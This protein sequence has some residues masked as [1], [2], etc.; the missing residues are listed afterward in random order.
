MVGMELLTSHVPR[1]RGT[2]LLAHGYAEHS[3]RYG[4]LVASLN[5]AGFETVAYDLS[6][7]GRSPGPRARVDVGALIV[8]HLNVRERV[9]AEAR[10]PLSLFG[11]SMG[12][13]ITAASVLLRPYGVRAVALS[14]PALRPSGGISP[15]LARALLPLARLAPGLPTLRLDAGLLSR[16]PATVAAYRAAPLVYHGRV[17]LLTGLTMVIQGDQVIRNAPMLARP[18][19]VLHG[20]RDRFA[21][22][23]GSREFVA[24][25]KGHAQLRTVP[26]GYHEILNDPG[27]ADL[28]RDVAAWLAAQ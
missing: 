14:A 23:E 16:D 18:T 15:R 11:H 2:V 21:R 6:G 8:E 19:L 12:G 28:C 22:P 13:L 27:G 4:R 10:A 24:R 5:E 20:E 3:G 1:P 7:H 17:P 25:S 9:A 26:G